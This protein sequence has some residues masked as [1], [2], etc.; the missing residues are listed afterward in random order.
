VGVPLVLREML[1]K[2]GFG[3]VWLASHPRDDTLQVALKFCLDE[4]AAQSLRHESRVLRQV[5]SQG[6]HAGIV[7]LRQIWDESEP[8]CLEYEYVGGET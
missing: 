5:R 7:Q 8:L 6:R 4:R 3:E 1:G 2:G